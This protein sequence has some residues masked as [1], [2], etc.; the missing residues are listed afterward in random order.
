MKFV[1]R[2]PLL[3]LQC[4]S[5]YEICLKHSPL[6]TL[7]CHSWYE[8]CLEGLL[9]HDMRFVLMTHLHQL[10][11]VIH[12]MKFVSKDSPLLTLRCHSWYEICFNDSSP[13]T[14]RSFMIW[15]LSQGLTSVNSTMSFMIWGRDC[16]TDNFLVV[17]ENSLSDSLKMS[18]TWLP[19]ENRWARW[20]F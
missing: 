14:R 10:D 19:N 15:N 17:H 16:N 20:L 6:L 9:I 1:S 5:W 4:H 12:D 2:T 8:I 11:D 13:S 7:Q 18:T 3:T